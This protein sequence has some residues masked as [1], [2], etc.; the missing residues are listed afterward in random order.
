MGGWGDGVMFFIGIEKKK[1]KN[2]NFKKKKKFM[3]QNI[4]SPH[5]TPPC[6][7]IEKN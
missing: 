3:K 1:I 7:L 6:T 2:K 5:P 4:Y